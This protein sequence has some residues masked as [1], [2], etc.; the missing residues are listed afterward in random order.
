M[1]SVPSVFRRLLR[2]VIRIGLAVVAFFSLLWF[3]GM[4]TPGTNVTK[5]AQLS[6]RG[7]RVAR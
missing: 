4:R 2:S 1:K 5:A 6:G 3:F 7:D